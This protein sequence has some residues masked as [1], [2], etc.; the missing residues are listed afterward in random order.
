MERDQEVIRIA[1]TADIIPTRRLDAPGPETDA[2]YAL[3]RQAHLAIGNFEIALVDDGVAIEKLMN[4]KASPAIAVDV[5]GLG[6]D[7][8]TIANNHS[9][10]YG[11]A[12]L[13]RTKALLEE[14]EV[15]VIGA[16][17]NLAEAAAPWFVE[18]V[19][20]KIGVIAFSCLTPTG[21]TATVDRAGIAPIRIRTAYEIDPWYQMEEPGDPA[22][23]R[24]RT[25][26]VQDDLYQAIKAVK[27]AKAT[28]DLLIV[29]IHWGFGSGEALA[30]YQWPLGQALID[31]GADVV[32]GHHPHAVHAAGFYRSKPILFGLGTFIGQQVF[33]PAS[34]ETKAMW[35]EMSP[36]GYVAMLSVDRSGVSDIEI[37]PTT[38]DA[39]RL[40]QLASGG[41]R[42]RIAAGLSRLS[43]P[44]GALVET[45]GHTIKLRPTAAMANVADKIKLK[46]NQR[47]EHDPHEKDLQLDVAA[48]CSCLGCGRAG[49]CSARMP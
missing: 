3:L 47:N 44:F 42:D 38:L 8:V 4:I 22:V 23:V 34:A 2:V 6:L 16:G 43:E 36:D 17:A 18:K 33:L 28:C 7:V 37:F 41:I 25:E 49:D 40:P 10:D 31:A 24:I 12:G 14:A 35:D 19:G 46:A 1:L 15:A 27:Q 5:H 21:M 26:P 11:Q 13:L 39:E 48:R 20:L 32:H 9:V 30:E 45:E 29:S